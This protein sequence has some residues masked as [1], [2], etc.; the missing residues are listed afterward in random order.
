MPSILLN[1]LKTIAINFAMKY[2]AELVV[3]HVI[4]AAEKAAAKTSTEIDD[5]V[6]AK[7]KADQDFIIKTINGSFKP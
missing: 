4:A 5:D 7:L 2:A 6:V 1:I 3:K